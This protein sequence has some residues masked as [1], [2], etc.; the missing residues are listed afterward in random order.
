[1]DLSM[2]DTDGKFLQRTKST[3][4]YPMDSDELC[5]LLKKS[6]SDDSLIKFDVS[7][8]ICTIHSCGL[9]KHGE[10]YYYYDPNDAF[11]EYRSKSIENIAKHIIKVFRGTYKNKYGIN[12]N[13][14]TLSINIYDFGKEYQGDSLITGFFTEMYREVPA[15]TIDDISTTLR[16][17]YSKFS[18]PKTKKYPYL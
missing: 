18:K 14:I 3:R 17:L 13:K 10:N 16:I 12:V 7:T 15:L 9:F 6:V 5:S 4:F 8:G 11:G 1:M 2:L